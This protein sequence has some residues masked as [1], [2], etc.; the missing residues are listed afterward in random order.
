L[1]ASVLC[2]V[3]RRIFHRLSIIQEPKHLGM[4]AAA[5]HVAQS[6]PSIYPAK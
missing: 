1:L 2:I 3:K 6:K 4:L 5:A